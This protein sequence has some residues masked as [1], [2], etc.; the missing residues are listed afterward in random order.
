MEN[1]RTFY[2]KSQKRKRAKK[3]KRVQATQGTRNAVERVRPAHAFHR[4]VLTPLAL[5]HIIKS[6]RSHK[7]KETV[8]QDCGQ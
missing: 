4:T 7:I 5:Y 1:S 6:N 2:V 8:P 3:K